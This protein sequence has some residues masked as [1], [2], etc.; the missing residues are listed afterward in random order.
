MGEAPRYPQIYADIS[1]IYRRSAR[2]ESWS[3]RR[4][5]DAGSGDSGTDLT[6]FTRSVVY[7]LLPLEAPGLAT[8]IQS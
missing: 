5:Y 6:R 8:S 2:Q 7:S 3:R 4:G 1:M